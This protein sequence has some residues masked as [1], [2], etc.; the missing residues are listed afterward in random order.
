MLPGG[1]LVITFFLTARVLLA[2]FLPEAP[3]SLV[4][5]SSQS[6]RIRHLTEH[7]RP[8]PGQST[9]KGCVCAAEP[10]PRSDS[11]P[12]PVVLRSLGVW[13]QAIP[14]LNTITNWCFYHQ[15]KFV[16]VRSGKKYTYWNTFLLI[17]RVRTLPMHPNTRTHTYISLR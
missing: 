12:N 1:C 16:L 5:K 15:K 13:L 14:L 11:S 8:F 6:C 2:W 10:W 9:W 3:V 7:V 4:G 17:W